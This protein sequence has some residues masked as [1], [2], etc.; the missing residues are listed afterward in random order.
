MAIP[1]GGTAPYTYSWNTV[2]V[3]TTATAINLAAGTFTVTITDNHSCTLPVNVT[4]TEPAAVLSLT[5]SKVDVDCF[6]NNTGTATATPAGGTAPYSYS[7]N[8]VPVQTT[9]TATGLTAGT[10]TVTVTDDHGCVKSANVA[11]TQPAVLA[12]TTTQVNVSC[13]GGTNGTATANVTGGTAP[14]GYSWNTLPVQTGVTATGLAAGSYTVTIKMLK[15][16]QQPPQLILQS[17]Q[18]LHWQQPG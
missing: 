2:P 1:A 13:N 18:I 16:A 12:V 17:H 11:V 14:Y 7:W 3:Q 4:I 10:Y 15:V 9:A 6:G 5:T 8:T